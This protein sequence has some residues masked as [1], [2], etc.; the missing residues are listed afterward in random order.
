MSRAT[1]S[2]CILIEL[3]DDSIRKYSAWDENGVLL[4]DMPRD[5]TAE[6][7]AYADNEIATAQL[8]SNKSTIELNLEEDLATMQAIKEQSNADIRAD[9]S[10]EVKEL[11][12]AVRR[13][14][15]MALEDFS[16]AE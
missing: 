3:W 2:N 9:P 12:V 6:E 5:Y 11:A 4:P 10:Q 7:N 13:L 8:A 1:Y 14:I 16:E 15:K